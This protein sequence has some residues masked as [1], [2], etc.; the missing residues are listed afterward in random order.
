MKSSWTRDQPEI[1][2]DTAAIE[3][4]LAPLFPAQRVVSF[5][6]VSGGLIN[7]NLKVITERHATPV[8]LRVYQ[9]DPAHAA[10]EVAITARIAGTV[11]VANSLYF[12]ATNPFSGHPYAILEWIDGQTFEAIRNSLDRS[13]AAGLGRSIGHTLAAIHSFTFDKPGFFAAD[14]SV[15]DAIDLDRGGLLAYLTRC[16]VDGPGGVR[17]GPELT[18]SILAFGQREGEMLNAWLDPPS[19]VHGDFN[20]PNILVRPNTAGDPEVAAVLDWEF[21]LSGSPALDFGNLLRPPLAH[22]ADFLAMVADGYRKAGGFLPTEWQHIARIADLF[23][24]A[25]IVSRPKVGPEVVADARRVVA[26][27]IA[28]REAC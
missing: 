16:L 25:D 7:T 9:G 10:K 12:S 8:L 3:A 23:A 15:P 26:D 4:L 13:A 1:A 14:L 11:P 21:A 6:Q 18:A 28:A 24:W 5:A 22:D 20:G 27:I 2:F 19:L 17:L